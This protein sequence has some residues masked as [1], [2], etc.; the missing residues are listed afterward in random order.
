LEKPIHAL[1]AQHRIHIGVTEIVAT[2][3]VGRYETREIVPGLL[4]MKIAHRLAHDN[5]DLTF[6]IQVLAIR[7]TVQDA[8]M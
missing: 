8:S 6:I 1:D 3:V 4:R 7:G 2:D 5:A